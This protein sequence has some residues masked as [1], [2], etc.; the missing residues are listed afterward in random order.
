MLGWMMRMTLLVGWAATTLLPASE[1]IAAPAACPVTRP[2]GVQP[3]L[4]AD[5]FGRG[6][7]DYGNGQLWTAL[8]TWGEGAISVP[9]HHVQPDGSLGPLKWPWWRG[10]AGPLVITGERLDAPAEPL[11]AY[12]PDGKL[13]DRPP[14]SSGEFKLVYP[15][16]AFHPTG[17]VFPTAGCWEITARVDEATLSF[18]TLVVVTN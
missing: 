18:V 11:Q 1:P 16:T 4:T 12:G 10:V 15:E 14:A 6:N 9:A 3:P 13:L 8:W 7:G 17:L 2:N 5:V